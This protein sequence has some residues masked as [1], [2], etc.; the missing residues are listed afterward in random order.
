MAADA[1]TRDADVVEH[2]R[3]PASRR[4]TV[5]TGIAAVYVR[6]VFA[7]RNEAVMTG[8]ADAHH[9]GVVNGKHR[10]EHVSVV[11]VFAD[12]ACL[13]MCK[14]FAC[15]VGAI[16][17]VDAAARDIDV[18]EIRGQPA[19][20]RMAVIAGVAAGDVV[21]CFPGRREAVMTGAT[22]AHHLRM[23]NG[24]Y[25]RKDIRVVAVLAD[26]GC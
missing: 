11:T 2:R 26:I 8:A 14:V 23:V 24:V 19:S 17:A 5:V 9:L 6:R 25:R 3:P 12:I 4:V 22:G 16:V 1:V 18:I 20:C 15:G 21:E 13:Y 7:G 10:G